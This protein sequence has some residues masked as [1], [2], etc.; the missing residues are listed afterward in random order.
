[1]PMIAYKDYLTPERI[2][3]LRSET[4]EEAFA[5]LANL[6][7]RQNPL[8]KFNQVLNEIWERENLVT[9]KVA[10]GIA[11]PHAKLTKLEN[12]IIV[13]GKSN[14]GIYYDL[15]DEKKV[16][17]L[18]MI[19]SDNEKY[20]NILSGI[21]AKLNEEETYR[22]IIGAKTTSEIYEILTSSNDQAALSQDRLKVSQSV[23]SHACDLFKEFQAKAILLYA[24]AV[25]DISFLLDKLSG[26]KVYLIT[27]NAA[28]YKNIK[29]YKNIEL[30]QVPFKGLNR[31]GQIEISQLFVAAKGFLKKGDK[32]ISVYGKRNSGLFDVV[33]ITDIESE[34]S[35]YF[36]F[37]PQI[38]P[39]DLKQEVFAR[40]IQLASDLAYEGREG[41][42][43][44]T[45]FVL[46]DHE[47]AMNYC[48]QMVVNP[49]KGLREDER[50]ILD[51][52][53]EETVKEFAK[54]DGAFIISGDGVILTSG[55]YLS[56]HTP[57]VDFLQ[58]LGARHA[59][60]ANITSATKAVAVVISE[61]TRKV[62][63]F[64]AGKRFIVF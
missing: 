29:N 35:N 44:G 26:E 2:I 13:V 23:F 19:L 46:G 20:L 31:T 6:I 43:V 36:S 32:V 33:M 58:G 48:Q 12:P 42:P 51:P 63:I 7:C 16:Y 57:A 56:T 25:G 9:T 28:R 18:I 41:K 30:V 50:N 61:S 27:N 8:L 60:A 49:F 17:L 59:A 37:E 39:S 21:A 62:S 3:F 1:M 10:E 64:K 45:I 54:L 22:K 38:L 34:F 15:C 24:D 11:I 5:E 52:S 47:N 55:A 14:K 4:K 53:L 40:A